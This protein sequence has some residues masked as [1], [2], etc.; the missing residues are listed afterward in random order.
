MRNRVNSVNR[1]R[2]AEIEHERDKKGGEYIHERT[3]KNNNKTLP[4]GLSVE[5]AWVVLQGFFIFT[6]KLTQTT[7]GKCTKRVFGFAFFEF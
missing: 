1:H 3:G 4:N 5:S 6:V 7:H 2:F